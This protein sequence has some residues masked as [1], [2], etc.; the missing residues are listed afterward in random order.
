APITVTST[1]APSTGT[2][3]SAVTVPRT[4]AATGRRMGGGGGGDGGAG[5]HAV[6]ERKA[7]SASPAPGGSPASPGPP[8]GRP[9]PRE[10]LEEENAHR[11]TRGNRPRRFSPTRHLLTPGAA[12]RAARSVAWSAPDARPRPT[13]IAPERAS[14]A[15]GARR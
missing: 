3:D 9:D 7:P 1:S 13:A 5:R 10:E 2:P 11:R 6:K 14:T 12:P 4:T 8:A 15:R